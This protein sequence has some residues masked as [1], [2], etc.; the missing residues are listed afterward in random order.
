MRNVRI[1]DLT[2]GY[3]GG[4]TLDDVAQ[5]RGC[6]P[7][8]YEPARK[9]KGRGVRSYPEPS[10]HGIQPAWGFSISHAEDITL[11]RIRLTIA[12]PDERPWL[13]ELDTK[14]IRIKHPQIQN[15]AS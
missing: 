9:E 12:T 1:S 2:I 4:I 5:Q 11:R 7:F 8:F 15:P 10:A 6:N 3:R 14:R 13:Y